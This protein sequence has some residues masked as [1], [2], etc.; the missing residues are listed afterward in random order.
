MLAARGSA[1]FAS[2]SWLPARY[3]R[4]VRLSPWLLVL[5]CNQHDPA[6]QPPAPSRQPAVTRGNAGGETN[7][8]IA[9]EAN[10]FEAAAQRGE[11]QWTTTEGHDL[12]TIGAR[13]THSDHFPAPKFGHGDV[14][15]STWLAQDGTLYVVGYMITG[16][17]GPD[18]GAIHRLAP[19]GKLER[20]FESKDRELYDVWGRSA[21]DVYAVGPKIIVH[22]D[23]HAWT[24]VPHIGVKGTIAHV[25]GTATGVWIAGIDNKPEQSWIYRLDGGRWIQETQTECMVRGLSAATSVVYASGACDAV[26]R[27]TPDGKWSIETIPATGAF[28]VVAVSDNVAYVAADVLVARNDDGKWSTVKTP[29]SRV[30]EVAR[31]SSDQIFAV[32]NFS[33]SGGDYGIARGA[34]GALTKLDVHSC[35]HP[36]GGAPIY[37]VHERMI[38]AEPP[39]DLRRPQAH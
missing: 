36:A 30:F 38:A 31:A 8:Q 7:E 32:G 24:E 4:I 11:I 34:E 9:A 2:R 17:S 10:A 21:T 13:G 35:E 29:F 12:V 6:P 20:V 5:A 26:Y 1:S 16:V 22:W 39:P 33:G 14:V 19:G 28:E 3:K 37:C 18:T 15:E 25:T 23:G 27:R